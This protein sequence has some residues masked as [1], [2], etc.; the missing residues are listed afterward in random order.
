MKGGRTFHEITRSLIPELFPETADIATPKT[1]YEKK[2]ETITARYYYYSTN[3]KEL[4][5]ATTEDI[6]KRLEDEFFV[7]AYWITNIIKNNTSV[8]QQ[9]REQKPKKDYFKIKWA[10]L[11][12]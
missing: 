9:L 12:W 1:A 5:F 7:S 2:V 10:H 8:I 4:G 3:S 6:L 11:V